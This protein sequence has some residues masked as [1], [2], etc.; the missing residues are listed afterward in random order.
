MDS[1]REYRDRGDRS[2]ATRDAKESRQPTHLL[3]DDN[4]GP[5]QPIGRRDTAGVGEGL[6]PRRNRGVDPER[7]V[8]DHRGA[9]WRGTHPRRGVQEEVRRRFAECH[10]GGAEDPL[11]EIAGEPR[12][13]EAAPDLGVP[14]ARGDA[15]RHASRNDRIQRLDDAV[16]GPQLG[17][18][19][20]PVDTIEL[21]IDVRRYR[22]ARSL[23]D[24]SS[25]VGIGAADEPLDDLALGHRPPEAIEEQRIDPEREPLA[26]DEDPVAVEDDEIEAIDHVPATTATRSPRA[27]PSGTH[28]PSERTSDSRSR[29]VGSS[30]SAAAIAAS[31]AVR[32]RIP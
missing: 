31:M 27:R 7:A 6:H 21:A 3:E 22:A 23:L 20:L 9:S 13:L 32:Q 26:V 14:A 25:H 24:L 16:D 12:E 8:L 17:L 2:V 1:P 4:T 10:V 28:S 5:G 18:E 19:R 30:A 11:V 29:I 15:D